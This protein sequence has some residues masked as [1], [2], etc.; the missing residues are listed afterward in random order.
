MKGVIE[1][2]DLILNSSVRSEAHA[3][4]ERNSVARITLLAPSLDPSTSEGLTNRFFLSPLLPISLLRGKM[5]ALP[6]YA[7][8]FTWRSC[9]KAPGVGD[10]MSLNCPGSQSALSGPGLVAGAPPFT[11]DGHMNA[12]SGMSNRAADQ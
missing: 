6:A 12:P 8:R 1:R 10:G 2:C 11:A 3:G 7:I 9:G 5:A 4:L